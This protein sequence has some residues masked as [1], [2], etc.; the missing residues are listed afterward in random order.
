MDFKQQLKELKAYK[1]DR[2]QLAD[3]V[4]RNKELF[5]VLLDYCF[6]K[7]PLID[8]PSCWVL[9]YVCIAELSW[10]HP[11]IKYFVR[12][13][14]LIENKSAKRC[15]AR[16]SMQLCQQ[17]FI[18]KDYNTIKAIDKFDLEQ[19]TEVNFDWLINDEKV[20]TKAYAMESLYQLG[21]AFKWVHPELKVI[22]EKGISQHTMAYSARAK[23]ILSNMSLSFS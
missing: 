3:Q 4:L 5:P 14:P 18:N 12:Q 15:C 7:D 10:I 9:E 23:H 17:F 11:Y 22:L 13:L 20:A 1:A 19:L 21:K 16:I 6:S 2:Q 8:R